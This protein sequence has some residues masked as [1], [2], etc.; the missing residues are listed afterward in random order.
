MQAAYESY[1][2]ND[3]PNAALG[4]YRTALEKLLEEIAQ[5]AKDHHPEGNSRKLTVGSP[6]SVRTFLEHTEFLESKEVKMLANFYGWI[7]GTGSHEWSWKTTRASTD[8]VM[9][10]LPAWIRLYSERYK[11]YQK[12]YS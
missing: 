11:E 10:L 3:D 4:K 12:K 7:S 9:V 8:F 1:T 6:Q 2:E 5:Y